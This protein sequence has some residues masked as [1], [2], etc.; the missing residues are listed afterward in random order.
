MMRLNPLMLAVAVLS[1][2]MGLGACSTT[3]GSRP[4]PTPYQP[5]GAQTYGYG[6]QRL[7]ADRWRVTFQGN[8]RTDRTLVEDS[9]LLRAAEIT[10]E[11]G[12]DWF[13]IAHRATDGE[14]LRRYDPDPF[15]SRFASYRVWHPRRGWVWVQDPFRFGGGF[16]WD[17]Q[18]FYRYEASAEIILGRG[19]KPDGRPDAYAAR[20]IVA[21]LGPRLKPPPP[22]PTLPAPAPAPA[23]PG[24]RP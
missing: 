13:Q 4:G 9:L 12:Y 22:V 19:A 17:Y 14:R 1:I 2:S 23:A 11:Q 18:D 20:D 8:T 15:S 10:V 16:G 24:S 6:E 7:E 5:A 21:N 3:A